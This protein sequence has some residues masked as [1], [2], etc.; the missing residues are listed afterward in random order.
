LVIEIVSPESETRDRATKLS[1]Y[2]AT[3][4]PEYW[5]IDPPR[6]EWVIYHL[7]QDGRYHPRPLDTQG[8]VNS[9]VLPGFA[10]NGSLLWQENPSG[11]PDL[12]EVARNGGKRRR[13]LYNVSPRLQG[14]NSASPTP[15]ASLFD[16]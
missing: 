14:L 7:G 12:I 15:W 11:S 3:G 5:L 8:C 4:V 16:G 10:L 1:E 6:T 9:A 13:I 2:E